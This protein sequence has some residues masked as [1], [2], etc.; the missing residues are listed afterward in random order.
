MPKRPAF[1]RFL[2]AV[3]KGDE[4]RAVAI[5]DDMTPWRGV[6]EVAADMAGPPLVRTLIEQAGEGR[7]ALADALEEAAAE[8]R[9]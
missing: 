1:V 7:E 6:A 4:S 5:L 2:L 9:R 8:L 3:V